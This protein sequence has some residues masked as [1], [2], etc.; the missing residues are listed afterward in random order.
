MKDES[1]KEVLP[2]KGSGTLE[3]RDFLQGLST[4]PVAGLFGYALHK[5]TQYRE[6][7]KARAVQK[8]VPAADH[9]DIN[10]FRNKS[11]AT[12]K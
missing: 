11:R 2:E 10:I 3:R 9:P 4:V 12:G 5:D 6:A 1:K 8:K 7:Q